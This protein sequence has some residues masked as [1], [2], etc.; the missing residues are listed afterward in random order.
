MV[1]LWK[2]GHVKGHAVD[3][4]KVATVCNRQSQVGHG[5]KEAIDERPLT[6]L[7]CRGD[8]YAHSMAPFK[9]NSAI[10]TPKETAD[11][12]R[13]LAA[14]GGVGWASLQLDR[15][16]FED[17]LLDLPVANEVLFDGESVAGL[18]SNG[19]ATLG[20]DDDLALD[21][22]D[23]FRR[24][25]GGVIGAGR[26]GPPSRDRRSVVRT[27]FD[28]GLH[29]RIAGDLLPSIEISLYRLRCPHTEFRYFAVCHVRLPLDHYACRCGVLSGC[30]RSAATISLGC[31]VAY[32]QFCAPKEQGQ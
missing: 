21:H 22:V 10:K 8:R 31:V 15:E 13:A 2:E 20:R 30:Q 16:V 24:P 19:L 5:T 7:V 3:A 18:H 32:F 9:Y 6:R 28:P 29:G 11:E 12:I 23:E 1:L 14:P 17:F 27:V 26:R 4:T 25:I